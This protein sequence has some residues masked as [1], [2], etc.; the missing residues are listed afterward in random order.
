MS[1]NLCSVQ[2]LLWWSQI[3]FRAFLVTLMCLTEILITDSL[4]D[5]IVL[6]VSVHAFLLTGCKPQVLSYNDYHFLSLS[7]SRFPSSDSKILWFSWFV[8]F[9]C[10]MSCNLT[11]VALSL[12][13][14][15]QVFFFLKL[16]C[17]FESSQTF[18]S[19]IQV[20]RL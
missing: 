17:L 11:I 4:W 13:E 8:T 1:L 18:L 3:S 12:L 19:C 20:H 14:V 9:L 6:L 5:A 16:S 15:A 10:E 2:A 7:E